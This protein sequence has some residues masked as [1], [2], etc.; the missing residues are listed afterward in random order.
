MLSNKKKSKTKQG[1]RK[2]KNALNK[3]DQTDTTR[4]NP[5][6]SYQYRDNLKVEKTLQKNKEVKESEVFE[7]L[8]KSA[9]PIGK[10]AKNKS[11]LKK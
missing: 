6:S 4:I 2:A 10:I 5:K 11:Q 8:P 1:S 3:I 7:G 9:K